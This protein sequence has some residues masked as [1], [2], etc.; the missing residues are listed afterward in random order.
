MHRLFQLALLA[1]LLLTPALAKDFR[2]SPDARFAEIRVS[3][4]SLADELLSS[5]LQEVQPPAATT[6]G[7]ASRVAER[8]S[9]E[10][11]RRFWHGQET[12]LQPAL[13]RVHDLLPVI[14]PILEDYGVPTE[15]AAVVLV[16]SA[17]DPVA[18]S[19]KGAGGLWQF[20]PETAR[21]YGLRVGPDGDERLDIAKS[22]RAAARHLRDLY[23]Q[24]GDWELALAAYNAGEATVRQALQNAGAESFRGLAA[25]GLLP[26]ETRQYVPAVMAAAEYFA[27]PQAGAG[28]V[29]PRGK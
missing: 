18:F 3:L 20:M 15:L 24:F 16:E 12:R 14:V 28:S 19:S 1:C 23:R 9:E 8:F 27:S 4:D 29:L 25:K 13:K 6:K 21:R 5:P 10:F 26:E 11:A 2:P 17:G 22:T 7:V